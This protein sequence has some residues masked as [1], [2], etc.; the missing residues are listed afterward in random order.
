MEVNNSV[1]PNMYPQGCPQKPQ[2]INI[3]PCN[4]GVHI[5][6]INP[7]AGAPVD[8]ASL[9]DYYKQWAMG[10]YNTCPCCHQPQNPNAPQTVNNDNSTNIQNNNTEKTENTEDYANNPNYK[11]KRIMVI[12]DDYIKTL[13]QWLNSQEETQREAAAKQIFQRLQEDK[14]RYDNPA[15]NALVN[16]M[17]QDPSHQVK[18]Y[19]LLALNSRLVKGDELTKNLLQNI[20][21]DKSYFGMDAKQAESI[22]LQM[23][24]DSKL[25]YERAD[26]K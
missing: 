10:G 23:S 18:S 15:L 24:A 21:Q 13:E 7:S 25:V 6:I 1:N 5:N 20:A 8:T 14:R 19:A 26:K 4:A 11:P 22:L 16:K 2:D 17:L 9:P 3:P 12:T